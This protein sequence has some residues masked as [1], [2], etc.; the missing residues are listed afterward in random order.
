MYLS[1]S[2]VCIGVCPGKMSIYVCVCV[3]LSNKAVNA[4]V[5]PVKDVVFILFSAQVGGEGTAHDEV[6]LRQPAALH[7]GNPRAQTQVCTVS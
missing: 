3:Y 1:G 7:P 2:N 6:V 4:C 5:C